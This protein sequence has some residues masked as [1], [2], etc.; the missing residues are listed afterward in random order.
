M[1]FGIA[2]NPPF[3]EGI[4][5]WDGALARSDGC[6]CCILGTSGTVTVSS[7]C[8]CNPCVHEGSYT[9]E[10][11]RARFRFTHESPPKGEFGGTPDNPEVLPEEPPASVGISFDKSAVIFEDEYENSPGDVVPRRSTRVTLKCTAYGGERGG[12]LEVDL[13]AMGALKL[14]S[15]TPPSSRDIGVRETVEFEAVYEG[16][17]ASSREN[18][19]VARVT[20]AE[21][22]T[23]IKFDD[24]AKITVVKIQLKAS[25]EAPENSSSSRH[26]YGVREKIICKQEPSSPKMMWTVLG[27]GELEMSSHGITY[28]CPLSSIEN[29]LRVSHGEVEYEPYISV[30][31]PHG[32][33]AK[34]VK[35]INYG[36]HPNEAGWVGMELEL[37]ITPLDVS[38]FNIAVEEVPCNT[39][40]V[41]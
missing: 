30:V 29:P 16:E 27:E 23:N 24:D 34:N 6:P 12:R 38:F 21:N 25:I 32:V 9:Y 36:K 35:N 20:F 14:V 5:E 2:V 3:V 15:G 7:D 17:A 26:K 37:Y 13:S 11:Y 1:S 10:G 19:T 4:V 8:E 31:E 22:E 28:I 40:P 33:L 41:L 39:C 18:G